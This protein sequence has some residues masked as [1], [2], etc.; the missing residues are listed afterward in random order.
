MSPFEAAVGRR[1]VLTLPSLLQITWQMGNT[2]LAKSTDLTVSHLERGTK[3]KEK[4]LL[5]YCSLNRCHGCVSLPSG[6]AANCML[7]NNRPNP[8]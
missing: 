8:R 1:R 4:C 6:E 7:P 2:S 3:K 5:L